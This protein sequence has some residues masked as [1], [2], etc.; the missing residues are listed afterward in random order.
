[1]TVDM[2]HALKTYVK[3]V[4]TRAVRNVLKILPDTSKRTPLLAGIHR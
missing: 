3:R 1:M 4:V 2:I